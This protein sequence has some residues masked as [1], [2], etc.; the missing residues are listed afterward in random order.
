ML[1]YSATATS[2]STLSG[3]GKKPGRKL[4]DA[5]LGFWFWA[6]DCNVDVYLKINVWIIIQWRYLKLSWKFHAFLKVNLQFDAFRKPVHKITHRTQPKTY[7]K[8][9]FAFV[10][11]QCANDDEA[12]KI[13]RTPKSV[14]CGVGAGFASWLTSDGDRLCS[15]LGPRHGE[16]ACPCAER[17]GGRRHVM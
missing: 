10:Y 15:C 16:V 2:M 12:L 13:V 5:S 11:G 6:A 17:P 1:L 9:V 4:A 8:L 14:T 3:K 7:S